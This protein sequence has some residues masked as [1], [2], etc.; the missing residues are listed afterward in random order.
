MIS[1]RFLGPHG[2]DFEALAECLR[3]FAG[4]TL[5]FV[6]N[7]GNAGDNLINLGTYCLFER[8][9]VAY[10]YGSNLETYPDRVVVYSG[11]GCLVPHYPGADTF[12]RNNHPVCKAMILLPH[13]VRAHGDMIA[14]MDERC[15]LFTR[16]KP[17]HDFVSQHI[18][19]ARLHDAHDMAFMLN[20]DYVR[21]LSWDWGYLSRK[22]L[23]RSWLTM[24]AKFKLIAKFR[25]PTLHSLRTDAETD[26]L[27][28][29]PLNF[30]MSNMFA[31]ADM[32]QPSCNNVAKALRMTMRAFRRV[33]TDRL[34]IAIF[35]SILGLEVEMRDNNYGKNHDIYRQSMAGRFDRTR[36][37]TAD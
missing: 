37:V 12:F 33:E 9:G 26:S 2:H 14:A 30:D 28:T 20:D 27:P 35:S 29:H 7:P 17:S 18:T 24:L 15:H 16:E 10:E 23:L 8:L 31:T 6:H 34:H 19:R 36:L 25:D 22:G 13:T 21:N 32:S 5:V 11:G 3:G 4:E 1:D